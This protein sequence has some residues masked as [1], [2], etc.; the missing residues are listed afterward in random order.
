[1]SASPEKVGVISEEVVA[2]ERVFVLKFF[3]TGNPTWI[4]RLFFAKFDPC[5]VRRN[6]LRPAFGE[7][8]FFYKGR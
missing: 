2:G 7:N 4:G 6:D 1:M 8:G 5:A 3:Q